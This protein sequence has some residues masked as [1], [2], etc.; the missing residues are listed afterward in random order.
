MVLAVAMLWWAG[1]EGGPLSGVATEAEPEIGWARVTGDVRA[2]LLT[3]R[4]VVNGEIPEELPRVA[5]VNLWASYCKPCRDEMPALDA[6]AADA[7]LDVAVVGIA[8]DRELAWA[9][10]FQQEVAVDFPSVLDPASQLQ[11]ELSEIT[12]VQWL[13]TTF[14]IVDGQ[15]EW[16]HLGPFD[17]LGKLR[18]AVRARLT[19]ASG[20][21]G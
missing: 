2:D 3:G 1:R 10:E 21:R 11:A 9:R 18:S 15:A 20:V 8:L 19:D 5:L 4:E 14:L 7:D 13:P 6:L 17:D 12:P 16:V